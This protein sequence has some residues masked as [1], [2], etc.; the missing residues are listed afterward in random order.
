MA[1]HYDC[2]DHHLTQHHLRLK[3]LIAETWDGAGVLQIFGLTLS[4]LSYRGH[5][6]DVFE[7]SPVRCMDRCL[8]SARRIADTSHV[9]CSVDMTYETMALHLDCNDHH[10]TQHHLRSKMLIAETRDRAGD[11]Q[12]FG[13]TLSQLSYRGQVFD[14]FEMSPVRWTCVLRAPRGLQ[15]RPM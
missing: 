9:T 12:I 5:V 1:L 6:F 14:F 11:L 10:L 8:E 13:L 4:Q 15:T 2:N 3:K 7:M